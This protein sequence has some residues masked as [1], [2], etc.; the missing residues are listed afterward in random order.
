[1]NDIEDYL[2]DFT[3]SNT[4]KCYRSG[5]NKF[6]KYVGIDA[7]IYIKANRDYCSDVKEF[8][9]RLSENGRP[10]LT[11]RTYLAAVKGYLLEND[12]ELSQRFWKKL[13]GRIRGKKARTL[14][15]VP[16]D[17]SI[18]R[19]IFTHMDVKGRALFLTLAS[20]GMRIGESLK[21]TLEDLDLDQ[22]PPRISI[23]GQY[24]KGGDSRVC[25][26]SSEA[27]EVL[28]EWLNRRDIWLKSSTN[29]GSG[30]GITKEID[31]DCVFPFTENIAT[32]IWNNALSK[33]GLMKLDPSTKR[34]TLHPHILRKWFRTRLGKINVDYTEAIMGH[35]GYLTDAYR[36]YGVEEV[37]K[38]YLENQHQLYIFTDASEL[39]RI[40]TDVDNR[41][42]AQQK[43]IETVILE[44]TTLQ[45]QFDV[46]RKRMDRYEEFTKKFG[47]LPP[48]DIKKF[49]EW[50]YG[51][52]H[53]EFNETMN[54]PPELP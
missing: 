3:S 39:A 47:P 15:E 53:K 50:Y 1:M 8:F 37:A 32:V 19:R 12:V 5:L 34:R 45:A 14:D 48:E 6:F 49:F 44:K 17:S 16:S 42:E 13:G 52:M 29:K 22:Q 35:A 54:Q 28:Q 9:V 23:R 33:A 18:L 11:V 36:R 2:N 41:I 4:R 51:E 26:I 31:D 46:L 25:F 30:L 24:T 10:P 40:R 21:I 43:L 20:S 38:W 27:K 7:E